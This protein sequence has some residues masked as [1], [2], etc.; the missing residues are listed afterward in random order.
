MR[1]SFAPI[2]AA[3]ARLP[4]NGPDGSLPD[5]LVEAGAS[6]EDA[7][8]EVASGSIT[9]AVDGLIRLAAGRPRFL[10]GTPAG[11]PGFGGG[12]GSVKKLL[13]VLNVFDGGSRF[14]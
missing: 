6:D 1:L 4:P 5:V 3:A 9:G 12:G 11:R 2:K 10:K 14:L 7:A 13:I 8:G